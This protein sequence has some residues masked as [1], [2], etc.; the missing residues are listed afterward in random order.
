MGRYF[1]MI[2]CLSLFSLSLQNTSA[3]AVLTLNTADSAPYSQPDDSGFYDQL[4]RAI[5]AG[6]NI[7]I[8]I[9]HLPSTRSISNADKGI[10]A[11][12]YARIKGVG[13]NYKNL[14]IVDEKL[15]DFNFTVFATDPDFQ[16]E[17]GW[18]SFADYNIA[19]ISGW[20]ILEKYVGP[21]K[22]LIKV[23]NQDELFAL[24]AGG[25][26]D[27]VI[28]ERWRGLNYLR[29]TRI[30]GI[31]PVSPPLASRGMFLYLHKNYQSM[32][33]GLEESLRKLKASGEYD[34]ILASTLQK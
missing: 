31:Y 18:N 11:G 21:S 24:L 10:D 9:N 23:A 15:I 8:K 3:A 12:E 20:K 5:F 13:K 32:I 14:L 28:Y 19:Y 22:S 26:A 4:V 33:P 2:V 7:Q 29:E 17:A 27:L 34:E 1:R 6:Q 25:R 16:L 30:D